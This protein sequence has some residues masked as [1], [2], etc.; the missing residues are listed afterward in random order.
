MSNF[1]EVEGMSPVA[2]RTIT[3][4]R[5]TLPDYMG[6]VRLDDRKTSD[7]LMKAHVVRLLGD[8]QLHVLSLLIHVAARNQNSLKSKA[9]YLEQ[10]VEM[11]TDKVQSA[12]YSFS[13]FFTVD[14]V[15]EDLQEKMIRDDQAILAA[16]GDIEELLE[17]TLDE[18]SDLE[19]IVDK[20]SNLTDALDSQVEAR[21]NDI[22]MFH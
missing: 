21:L 5:K 16:V 17:S 22:M 15:P 18:A 12:P 19:A 7:D 1:E 3:E 13:P 11:L 14:K 20:A 10:R 6:F 8:F 2:V 9:G 4:V